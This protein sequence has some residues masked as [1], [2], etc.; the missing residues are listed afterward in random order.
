MPRLKAKPNG[1]KPVPR[2]ASKKIAKDPDVEDEEENIETLRKSLGELLQK[3]R[4]LNYNLGPRHTGS[5]EDLVQELEVWKTDYNRL[6]RELETLKFSNGLTEREVEALN[7]TLSD[8][9]T[10]KDDEIA[11]LK[12]ENKADVKKYLEQIKE[13]NR[14]QK[15]LVAEVEGYKSELK[16]VTRRLSEAN[17]GVVELN[18]SIQ[19]LQKQNKTLQ[20]SLTKAMT[21]L[22]SQLEVKAKRDIE[23]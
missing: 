13:L 2:A 8:T 9:T 22:D 10:Y 15:N 4:R 5:R 18:H 7:A 16:E 14:V 20:S 23:L 3:M 19:N 6:E 12:R 1:R 11:R 17:M 21:K